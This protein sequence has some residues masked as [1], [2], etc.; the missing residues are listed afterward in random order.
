VANIGSNKTAHQR[1]RALLNRNSLELVQ[2]FGR[3]SILLEWW[4]SP[5]LLVVAA[6]TVSYWRSLFGNRAHVRSS[7]RE[8]DAGGMLEGTSTVLAL[9]IN[10]R[11]YPT[12]HN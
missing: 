7:K 2:Q 10:H 5:A 4:H 11:R 6:F 9:Q 8:F 1:G 3:E 12:R